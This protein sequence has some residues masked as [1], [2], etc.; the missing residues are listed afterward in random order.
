MN[1]RLGE[2]PSK[3]FEP[4]TDKSEVYA[5]YKP[6]KRR[7]SEKKDHKNVDNIDRKRHEPDWR[8]EA[9]IA[10]TYVESKVEIIEISS[11]FEST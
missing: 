1:D 3:P 7:E 9:K 4:A 6:S 11:N 2:E 8:N 5:D 10:D